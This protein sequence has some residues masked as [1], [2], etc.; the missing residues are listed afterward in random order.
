[1]KDNFT[2][3]YSPAYKKVVIPINMHVSTG[4]NKPRKYARIARLCVWTENKIN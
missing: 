2:S 1:M 4:V 3:T